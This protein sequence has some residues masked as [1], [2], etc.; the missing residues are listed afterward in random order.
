MCLLGRIA[1]AILE[2]DPILTHDTTAELHDLTPDLHVLSGQG[3]CLREDLGD[4]LPTCGLF[5]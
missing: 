4:G 2:M 1:R 5:D 3:I